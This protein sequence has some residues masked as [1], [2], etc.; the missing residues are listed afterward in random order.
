MSITPNILPKRFDDKATANCTGIVDQKNKVKKRTVSGS[1]RLI[2]WQVMGWPQVETLHFPPGAKERN[3]IKST[4]SRRTGLPFSGEELTRRYWKNLSAYP[5]SDKVPHMCFPSVE[6]Y[7]RTNVA[8]F[9]FIK[10][11]PDFWK[12]ATVQKSA[13]GNYSG[14]VAGQA[15]SIYRIS[16]QYKT[17]EFVF[18]LGTPSDPLNG[19]GFSSVN[20][21]N[22][23]IKGSRCVLDGSGD[24][25][26][27]PEGGHHPFIPILIPNKQLTTA[28]M[29]PKSQQCAIPSNDSTWFS[30][31]RYRH[32]GKNWVSNWAT[33]YSLGEE[34]CALQQPDG[35]YRLGICDNFVLAR[36]HHRDWE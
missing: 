19:L 2:S 6:R 30:K 25:R 26:R 8:L 17:V 10:C 3:K 27:K 34:V 33:K 9:I 4:A 36:S 21:G 22:T 18:C 20:M 5:R 29:L 24:N 15:I 1:Q 35:K 23:K 28:P 7:I 12:K 14:S 32:M 11:K 13:S 31:Y 16:S